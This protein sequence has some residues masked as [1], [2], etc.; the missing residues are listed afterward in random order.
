MIFAN[1]VE[2]C[3]V[4]AVVATIVLPAAAAVAVVVATTTRTK[5]LVVE[6]RITNVSTKVGSF[7]QFLI[8][9]SDR[10]PKKYGNCRILERRSSF[11]TVKHGPKNL[12]PFHEIEE[13]RPLCPT[14]TS[15]VRTTVQKK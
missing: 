1:I 3:S 8:F 13:F 11:T 5:A 9:S 2:F 12:K 15:T 14:S 6:G 7:L 10:C 4:A